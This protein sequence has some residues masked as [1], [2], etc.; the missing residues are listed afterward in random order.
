M[1]YREDILKQLEAF[2]T[3]QGKPVL[4]H[5]S[6]RAIGEIEGGADTLLSALIA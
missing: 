4:V 1:I 5:T 6:L 2:R 3:A